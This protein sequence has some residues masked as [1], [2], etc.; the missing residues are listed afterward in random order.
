MGE[1]APEQI[2][3]ARALWGISKQARRMADVAPLLS[4][5]AFDPTAPENYYVEAGNRLLMHH[6]NTRLRL[7]PQHYGSSTY[8][9]AN[10]HGPRAV[11]GPEVAANVAWLLQAKN[12]WVT[13]MI[14][15]KP[16]ERTEAYSRQLW[17]GLMANAEVE[18][19]KL[20]RGAR[21]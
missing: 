16:D 6:L 19:D 21:H 7:D 20:K 5:P 8:N 2:P 17:D 1:H 12:A 18:I 11:P 10:R 4:L 13:E 9:V 14:S 15:L 3:S